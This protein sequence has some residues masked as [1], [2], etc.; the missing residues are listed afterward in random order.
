MKNIALEMRQTISF[1]THPLIYENVLSPST[2]IDSLI[3]NEEMLHV[4][5][6]DKK[7]NTHRITDGK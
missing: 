7:R 5:A 1:L 3:E 6:S 2:F 4:Q